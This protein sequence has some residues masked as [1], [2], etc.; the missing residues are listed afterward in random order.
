MAGAPVNVEAAELLKY[1]YGIYYVILA[2]AFFNCIYNIIYRKRCHKKKNKED[3]TYY[4]YGGVVAF[5]IIS[6]LLII[7]LITAMIFFY[8][9]DNNRKKFLATN[10]VLVFLL[11]TF[12][13]SASYFRTCNRI[14]SNPYADS[15]SIQNGTKAL[16]IVSIFV[17][18]GSII[19]NFTILNSD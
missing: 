7:A 5:N 9:P 11:I 16:N 6:I 10:G 12:I 19:S 18:I 14:R 13:T 3:G 8:V 2:I 15:V 17:I 1:L 4:N